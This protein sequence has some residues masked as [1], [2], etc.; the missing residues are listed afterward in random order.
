M[1]DSSSSSGNSGM[2]AC[3]SRSTKFDSTSRSTRCARSGWIFGI[4]SSSRSLSRDRLHHPRRATHVLDRVADGIHAIGNQHTI[5]EKLVI[6][7]DGQIIHA[8]YR[9]GFDNG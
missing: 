4:R 3:E 5:G 1:Y 6:L 8:V 2:P 7:I 9:S